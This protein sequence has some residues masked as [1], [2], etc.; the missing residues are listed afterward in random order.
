MG[1]YRTKFSCPEFL[2][3]SLSIPFASG[4]GRKFCKN[5]H[6]LNPEMS[7]KH[8]RLSSHYLSPASW[9]LSYPLTLILLTWRIWWAPDNASKCHM[10]FNSAFKG[11]SV[12][13]TLSQTAILLCDVIPDGKTYYTA[14]FWQSV[15]QASELSFPVVFHTENCAVHTGNPTVSSVYLPTPRW[16]HL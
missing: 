11:L 5:C 12:L 9:A 8:K 14:Q 1:S 16:H 3:L 13:N 10:G 6:F 7:D 4:F 15:A 2:C